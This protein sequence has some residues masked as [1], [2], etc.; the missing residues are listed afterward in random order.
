LPG[1]ASR[2]ELS[3]E[4]KASLAKV[5][6][7][8]QAADKLHSQMTD[9]WDTYY[10]LSMNWNRLAAQHAKA[11][12]PNDKDVVIQA[13][14]RQ[15]GEELFVPYAFTV[16]ETNLPRI[17][18]SSPT[19][20]VRPNDEDPQTLAACK[21]LERLYARDN[22]A[23]RYERK[24]QE[25][26]RSGLRYG[27]G[28]QKSYWQS[29]L[30]DGKA[31]VPM[32]SGPGNKLVDKKGIIVFEGP[33]VESVDVYDFFWDPAAR[34][35][36]TADYVIH[37]TWRTLDYIS[38]RVEEGRIRRSE[39]REGGWAELDMEKVKGMGSSTDRGKIWAN[40]MMA[41][42]MTDYQ[43]E[44]NNLHEVWELH[45]RDKVITVLDRTLVVQ[46]AANP[47]LHG[48]FPFQIYRPT[49][50]EQEFCG[51]GE[52]QPIS[53]LQFELN[54]MRGQR[55]D[56]ATLALNRG[57]F[58]QVGGLDPSKIVT[59]VGVFN[60]VFGNP[61]E[62]IQ[63]MPFTDIPQSGVSEEEALKSDIE[64]ASGLS[65][66][67]VGA[68]SA[69][70]TATGTQL[71]QQAA[72]LRI[73]Q[74]AKNLHVDLLVPET[75]QRKALYEAHITDE[76]QTQTVRVEDGTRPTGFAFIAVGPAE[77]TA[78]VEPM[79]VDGS[80]EA[81]NPAQ[82][83]ND[84]TELA[85]ALAPFG[86]VVD[87]QKLVSYI[88]SQHDVEKPEDWLKPQ[89][90]DPREGMAMHIGEALKQLGVPEDKIHQALELALQA[91]QGGEEP[92]PEGGG[93]AAPE[94]SPNGSEP[95]PAP[96][97]G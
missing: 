83:H 40:R 39:N 72:N 56:A 92:Q 74:K 67:L 88:L 6:S 18:S 17:L 60:P 32:E 23:M 16:I 86:E 78:N 36:E 89:G 82:K 84:A 7:R 24:L 47:F 45:D 28:V 63:P 35:L 68:S 33:Q 73:R 90:P 70:E 97:G 91:Q 8:F 87:T 27:L 50:V 71:V 41:A 29:K 53:H 3:A 48:D 15:F 51:I 42:G 52:V 20:K 66:A 55:R 77:V 75:A 94:P 11:R 12:V 46:E 57:Y 44:G 13:M 64:L 34:D 59:G 37:R 49:I 58:Y 5:E 93:Q 19:I 61:S 96:T 85:S 4:Q 69:G 14:R 1:L 30:R 2:D 25:T 81:E 79:P 65:E 9:R 31:L 43:T 54:T 38:Q 76:A 95:T 26:V 22:A 80:T 62:I 10:A 21:P